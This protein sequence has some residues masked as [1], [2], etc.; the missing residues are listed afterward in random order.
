M[1]CSVVGAS[2]FMYSHL[3]LP[4]YRV[5]GTQRPTLREVTGQVNVGPPSGRALRYCPHT[6]LDNIDKGDYTHTHTNAH[7]KQ[8]IQIGN[9]RQC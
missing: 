4:F 5:H 9:V 8:Q 7:N 3:K 6:A 1:N 2:C